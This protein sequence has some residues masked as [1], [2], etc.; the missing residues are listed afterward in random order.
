MSRSPLKIVFFGDSIC[1]GQG[2]SIHRGWV[3][4]IS[5]Q[6]EILGE[7]M[8]RRVVVVNSS[9]NGNTTRQALERMPYDVQSQGAEIMIVQF[10]MNDCNH[11][12]TDK[13]VPRVSREAFKANLQEI[14]DRA[15]KHSAKTIILNTNHATLR[16]HERLAGTDLTYED[17]NRL[18]N[19]AIRSVAKANLLDTVLNDMEEAFLETPEGSLSEYLLDD[20][21]H[22]SVK[23]HDMY[24]EH[25]SK[26]LGPIIREMAVRDGWA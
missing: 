16:Q 4:R 10:G 6:L 12:V 1:F 24:Y 5:A 13:G 23:G 3:T 20:H 25:I 26:I 21:L 8:G 7:Q 19:E 17:S 15:R 2:V 11:W 9:I 22:L 14:I 18:Y